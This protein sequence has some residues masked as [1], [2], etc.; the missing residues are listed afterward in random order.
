MGNQHGKIQPV[1]LE[2]FN[3]VWG[4]ACGGKEE[5]CLEVRQVVMVISKIIPSLSKEEIL[6][7]FV[8]FCFVLFCFVLFYFVLYYLDFFFFPSWSVFFMPSFD[9]DSSREVSTQ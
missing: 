2:R 9:L 4:K 6:K 8:L 1:G 7:V 3:R 5:D